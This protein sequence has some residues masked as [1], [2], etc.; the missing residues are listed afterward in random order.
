[1][2]PDLLS[3]GARALARPGLAIAS[4]LLVGCASLP[5]DWGLSSV[6]A[7]T[8]AHGRPLPTGDAARLTAD[9]LAQPLNADNAITVA[10]L[11]NPAVRAET[12][13]LGIAAAD[14]Y[15]AARISN[16]VFTASRLTS[17]DPTAVSAQI[18][19]GIAVSF[20][21]LLLLPA[22]SHYAKAQFETAKLSVGNAAL[23]LASDVEAGYYRL[24]GAQQAA[25]MRA[26]VARTGA[27][28]ADL[29]QRFFD[30]GN[31]S[32]R[33]LAIEK[34]AAAQ[35]SL[36]AHTAAVEVVTTKSSLNRLMGLA[37]T[38]DGWTL[39]T[40]LPAPLANEDALDDLIQYAKTARLDV[41]AAK[42]NAE[43]IASLYGLERKTRLLGPIELGYDDE[44]ETD[45]SHVRGPS[46][47]WKIPLF[48]WGSGRVARAKAQLQLAEA[49]LNSRELDASNEVKLA[50]ARVQSAKAMA[51]Q[52]RTGL[53][54]ERE[55]VVQ[56]TQLEVNY[57]LVG[58]FDLVIA[59]QQ[60]YQAYAGYLNAVRDYWVARADL[61]RAVGQKLPSSNLATSPPL[62][63]EQLSKPMAVAGH[64]HHPMSDMQGMDGMEGMSPDMP[65]MDM[66]GMEGMEGMDHSGHSMPGMTMPAQP[67]AAA[68]A[69]KNAEM[70]AMEGMEGMAGMHHDQAAPAATAKAKQAACK[71][72]KTADASD[73]LNQAL[74]VKCKA[75]AMHPKAA[76]ESPPPAAPHEHQH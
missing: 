69:A 40:G 26:A 30:A 4:L 60:E 42:A 73:P 34:S 46:L 67:A 72:L 75:A 66:K 41:A 43:A 7:S 27:A 47:S 29:A 59:K 18:G 56:Q 61:T 17:T 11:N 21:D 25:I 24:A 52:Y 22:R 14:V 68:A 12:A 51:E 31:I 5:A 38:Q 64:G 9:L 39:A 3:P 65:G 8:A 33:E 23:S 20:T 71:Q 2:N 28:S 63:A 50:Y 16:P 36:D 57:M 15:D 37:A 35:A 45:G 19:I 48:N 49:E 44:K 10:L 74:L 1:M 55:A 62:D 13:R 70:P 76:A 32:R 58:V 54:P 53:I 6:A